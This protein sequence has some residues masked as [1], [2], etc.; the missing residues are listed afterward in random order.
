MHTPAA[1]PAA[2]LIPKRRRVGVEFEAR[3]EE[4]LHPCLSPGAA[5]PARGRHG[6]SFVK[7]RFVKTARGLRAAAPAAWRHV[8]SSPPTWA[9]VRRPAAAR[10][11]DA[12]ERPRARHEPDADER[13][14]GHS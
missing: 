9:H 5:P 11:P 14:D 12:D 2:H 10:E 13:P 8:T 1:P 6:C 7:W 3:F 4:V